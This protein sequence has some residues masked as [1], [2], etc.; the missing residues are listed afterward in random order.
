MKR[1]V[2]DP[3]YY[4]RDGIRPTLLRKGRWYEFPQNHAERFEK[5]GKLASELPAAP[6]TAPAPRPRKTK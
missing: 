3:F 1:Q 4:A 5:E 6:K 2:I